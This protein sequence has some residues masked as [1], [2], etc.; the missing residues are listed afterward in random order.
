MILLDT[1]EAATELLARRSSIYSSRVRLPMINELMGWNFDFAFMPYNDYWRQHRKLM[2]QSFHPTASTRFHPHELRATHGLLRSLLDTPNDFMNHIR[3][4]AG[5]TIISVAYG[6]DVLPKDDPYITTAEK[7]VHPLVVAAVP[8]S[9]LV[10]LIPALK[11]VPDWLPFAGFKRKAKE[12]REL[13]R[14]MVDVPYE[15]A[16]RNIKSGNAAPSFTSYSLE[17]LDENQDVELQESV[18]RNA[19]GTMFAAGSETTLS[20]IASSILG[21]LENPGA[22]KKAQEEVDR[23]IG[24]G[25]LPTF[26]DE[27][28]LP[29]VTAIVKETMRWRDVTPIAIPHLLDVDDEYKGYFLP[30]GSIVVPNA[31][32]MLHDETIYPEP[33]RF[34]PDRFMKDGKI[35]PAIRDPAHAAFGFGRRICPAR[36]MATSAIW[37]AVALMVATFDITKAVDEDG[38]VIE[39][40][41][42]TRTGLACVPM[43]FECSITPR[44]E[45]AKRLIRALAVNE[46]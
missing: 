1:A 29:Y 39:P 19:A 11:Y 24:K 27:H 10:D 20:V 7:G 23:V 31:W 34:N 32:A 25:R 35:N 3:Q 28:S 17:I 38:N 9:F 43:P 22:L 14:M 2:H 45:N 15:A 8:G 46:G 42:E 33:F 6:L 26:D 40:K 5:E 30:A 4:L 21:F 18:I 37:I 16:K 44:S 36:Y 13:G 12:W 41:N